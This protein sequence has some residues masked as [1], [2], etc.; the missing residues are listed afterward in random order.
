MPQPDDRPDEA[1]NRLGEELQAFE[2]ERARPASSQAS[3]SIGEGYRLLAE[4]IG[5]VLGGVGL[6]WLFDR[7]ANTSPWGM[8]VGV[9][10]G[11]GLSVFMAARTAVRM[12]RNALDEGPPPKAVPLDDD[13]D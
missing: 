4:L 3:R 1:L 12:G 6:G 7:L 2:A 11:A 8:A 13:E 10:L 9:S 5:G